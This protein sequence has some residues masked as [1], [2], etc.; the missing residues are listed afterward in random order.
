M[1]AESVSNNVRYRVEKTIG[2]PVEK[3]NVHIRAL[4]ISDTD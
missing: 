1:V 2:I 4:R 3:V